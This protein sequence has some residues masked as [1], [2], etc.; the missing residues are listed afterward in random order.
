MT[1]NDVLVIAWLVLAHLIADFVLQTDRVATDKF[2]TGRRAWRGLAAHGFAVAVAMLPLPFAFGGRGLVALLAIS[3]VHAVIDRSKV[4]LTRRV[5][6][7]ALEEAALMH[8]APAVAASLGSAWTP[9]PAGLFILDQIAHGLVILFGW[10]IFL[11]GAP[12]DSG[13]VNAWTGVLGG[14]DQAALHRAVLSGV[15][16]FA[17]AIVNVRAGSLFVATLVNPREVILG[18]DPRDSGPVAGDV[19]AAEQA[20]AYTFRVG[21]FVARAEPAVPPRIVTPAEPRSLASPERVGEAIGILERLLIVTFVLTAN[22]A[23]IGFV[24]AAKTLARFKQ[25]DDRRFAEYYLLGTLASVSVALA[26]GLL[27]AAALSA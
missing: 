24:V 21:P 13:W 2:A 17:L 6:A 25:L 16:I 19:E 26:S 8:E 18:G 5:E 4:V 12:L 14:F 1:A 23:A 27:A 20:P 9:V 15:V 10:A 22:Q 11:R 3:I 7:A